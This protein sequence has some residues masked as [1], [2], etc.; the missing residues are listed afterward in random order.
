MICDSNA[1][2]N[3]SAT[4]TAI[5]IPVAVNTAA[6]PW[7]ISLNTIEGISA[8]K[9]RNIAPKSVI[10]LETRFKCSVVG[11]PGLIPGMKPP[12]CWIFLEISSGLN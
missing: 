2:L 1:V 7:S 12:F 5:N 10:L 6:E 11:L 9:A 3:S 4:E 8:T